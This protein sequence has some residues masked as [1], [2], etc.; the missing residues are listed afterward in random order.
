MPD[1]LTMLLEFQERAPGSPREHYPDLDAETSLELARWTLYEDRSEATRAAVNR[2]HETGGV[3]RAF[4]TVE[5]Q[6]LDIL[7]R[8]FS[9]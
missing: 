9:D 1:N 5:V 4:A 7:I 6:A 3:K 8:P 2:V